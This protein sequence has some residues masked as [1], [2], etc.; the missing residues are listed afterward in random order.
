MVLPFAIL[1]LFR[2]SLC[3]NKKKYISLYCSDLT[4]ELSAVKLSDYVKVKNI[5]LT[6]FTEKRSCKNSNEKCTSDRG[7]I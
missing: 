5:G 1:T 7:Q 6:G 4:I 2:S 3:K